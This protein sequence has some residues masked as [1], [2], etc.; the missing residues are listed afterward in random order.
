[1]STFLDP[2]TLNDRDA[3]ADAVF[4]FA[5]GLDDNDA[6]LVRS[7]LIG[8]AVV[9]MT[10]VSEA[11]GVMEGRE[12]VVGK[13]IG[14][15][16]EMDTTHHVSNVRA[17]ISG[18]SAELTCYALAQHFRPGEGLSIKEGKR[19]MLRGNRYHAQLER[20]SDWWR[21]RHLTIDGVWITGDVNLVTE[22]R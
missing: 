20:S 11:V 1:M 21:I 18:D 8:D 12:T 2:A 3:V 19:Y 7:A 15:L 17:V 14:N 16:G 6:D 4:R 10:G 13:L 9:D 22:P 5:Q